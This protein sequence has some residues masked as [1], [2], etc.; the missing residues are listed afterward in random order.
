MGKTT[1]KN[2]IA[3][4]AARASRFWPQGQPEHRW[5]RRPCW[6]ELHAAGQVLVA[7]MGATARRPGPDLRIHPAGHWW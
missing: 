1:T 3:T 7:E 2:A 6:N 4:V 5:G